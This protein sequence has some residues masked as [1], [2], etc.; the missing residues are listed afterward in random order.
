MLPALQVALGS[1]VPRSLCCGEDSIR[2]RQLP[3]HQEASPT[4]TNKCRGGRPQQSSARR[5]VHGEGAA[6]DRRALPRCNRVECRRSEGQ[7]AECTGCTSRH[8]IRFA[9]HQRRRRHKKKPR[10][11]HKLACVIVDLLLEQLLQ[12]NF[13]RI[14]NL[15]ER[16]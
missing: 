14:R 8:G 9:K 13:E 7:Q 5:G 4:Q 3:S 11:P 6:E 2:L 16:A 10:L 12:A 15:Y 1:D